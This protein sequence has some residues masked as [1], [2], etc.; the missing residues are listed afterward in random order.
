[1]L[2]SGGGGGG[3]GGDA[4]GRRW[5][6]VESGKVGRYMGSGACGHCFGVVVIIKGYFLDDLVSCWIWVIIYSCHRSEFLWMMMLLNMT[7]NMTL[8]VS[9]DAVHCKKFPSPRA[10]PL[11]LPATRVGSY[12]CLPGGHVLNYSPGRLQICL[13]VLRETPLL[14]F[15]F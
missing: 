5:G 9:L 11:L 13:P 4:L 3:V 2:D 14:L 10:E 15:V 7:L 12:I 1:M 8:N 6:R